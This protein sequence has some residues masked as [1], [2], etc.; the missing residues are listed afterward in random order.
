[1]ENN[2]KKHKNVQFN[3]TIIS[4]ELLSIYSKSCKENIIKLKNWSAASWKA[5]GSLIPIFHVGWIQS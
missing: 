2:D 4:T 1:M 3:T 5:R